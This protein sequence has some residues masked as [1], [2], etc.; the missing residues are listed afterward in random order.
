MKSPP[1]TTPAAVAI[2]LI[3]LEACLVRVEVDSGRGLPAFHLV[4]L[5]EACVRESRTRVRAALRHVGVEL[6][7]F[8]ITVN[9]QPADLKK[10]GSGFDLAIALA[11]LTALGKVPRDS[12]TGALLLGELSLSGE[13]CAVR[14]VLPA[15]L[16][17]RTAGLD[18]AI[19]PTA[20]GAEAA[21]VVGIEA[22]VATT[23]SEIVASVS[24]GEPLARAEPAP[25]GADDTATEDFAEVRG[26]HGARRML[27]L[28]AAGSH[29]VLMVG[30]PGTGKTMLARRLPTILPAMTADE[31]L[32]VTSIHSVA[33]ALLD[34][35][36]VRKRPFRAP[37]H[38]LSAP[39]LFGGGCPVRPG[40]I[41]LAHHG[42]LF[43]D[44]LLEFRRPVLE[45]MRQPL[46]DGVVTICR[47]RHRATFPARPLLVA[48]V[49][50][51]PCGFYGSTRRCS[52]SV[53]QV[54]RYKSRLSGPLLD[55][56]DL[57]VTLP[58]TNIDE[59]TEGE[60]GEPSSAIR[61]RVVR[62]RALQQAR[63]D[64]K[65]T[66]TP[67]NASLTPT[68]LD[69]VA[70]LCPRSRDLLRRAMDRLGMSARG[71]AKVRRIARTIA[72]LDGSETLRVEHV[73]EAVGS[74][75]LDRNL[76]Q[77]AMPRAS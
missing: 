41:S 6:N 69:A 21:A 70:T 8:A 52:C 44:E 43:L 29:N 23:L 37:H 51:C 9:L 73:S 60:P 35:G 17:A 25:L 56:I 30:P 53:E 47:A 27:E 50:P 7:E 3:G 19:V 74:R 48:A 16:A 57:H 28:A 39:A 31:A 55:R 54:H 12:F 32:A 71:Y 26:Q 46:E 58:A 24:G 75:S 38:T 4:G 63:A 72:D 45:G 64:A 1:V 62:A 10:A 2:T 20:N 13:M 18:R 68:D 65:L 49:N 76:E 33:G 22:R 59:L 36:L 5:P 40:E 77:A 11:V 34:H 42:C 66:S 15:L 61:E 67:Y 14:G